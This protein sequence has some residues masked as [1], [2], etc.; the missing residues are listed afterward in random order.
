[1]SDFLDFEELKARVT[2]EDAVKL[3][4]LTMTKKGEQL[5]A[6]CPACEGSKER[7]LVV[8]PAKG[9]FYC[10][11]AKTG[12]DQIAL[13]SHLKGLP[14]KEAARFLSG[15]V[16]E[17]KPK[18]EKPSVGFK[19]LDYL[20]PEHDAVVALGLDPDVAQALGIGYAPRGVLKDTV[21][22][23]VRNR[24]GSIAGYIGLTDIEKLPPKWELT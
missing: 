3:C 12:G 1:M 20:Q 23:P 17:E 21:A 7:A 4:N 11:T 19:Q 5:R 24:D 6:Q 22:V 14:A 10:F 2:I 15:T 16:P 9:V 13:V 8:T 18:A